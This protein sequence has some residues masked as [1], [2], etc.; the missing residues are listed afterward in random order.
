MELG[1]EFDAVKEPHQGITAFELWKLHKERRD[2]RQEYL[3][4]WNGTAQHTRTGRPIDAIISPVAAYAAPP[5][6]KNKCASRVR[7]VRR[8]NFIIPFQERVIHENLERG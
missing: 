6:G 4:A 3:K 5:H 1:R 8:M 2:I 7:R